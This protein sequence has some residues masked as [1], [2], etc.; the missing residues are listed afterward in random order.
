LLIDERGEP[1][2]ILSRPRLLVA[3]FVTTVVGGRLG[4]VAPL[5]VVFREV[6]LTDC[7]ATER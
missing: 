4:R 7:P 5:S 3:A 1:L 6:A 2:A